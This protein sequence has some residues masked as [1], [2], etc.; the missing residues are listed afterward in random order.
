MNTTKLSDRDRLMTRP[1]E[2]LPTPLEPQS[3]KAR[4]YPVDPKCAPA[5]GQG[6][7]DA[8]NPAPDAVERTA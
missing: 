4:G 1:A 6:D 2:K 3:P 7:P 8:T 5:K